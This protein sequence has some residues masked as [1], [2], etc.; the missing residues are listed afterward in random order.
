MGVIMYLKPLCISIIL[1]CALCAF[2]EPALSISVSLLSGGGGES[3]SSSTTYNLDKSAF[4]NEQISLDSGKL[5]QN[6]QAGGSGNNFL[7]QQV[8]DGTHSLVNAIKSEGQFAS[9]SS[10]FASS[11]SSAFD[12]QVAGKGNLDTVIWGNDGSSSAGQQ[13]S[14]SMGV[15]ETRQSLLADGSVSTGQETGMAGIKGRIA[16]GVFSG[17]DVVGY[18][19]DFL[20][21]SQMKAAIAARTGETTTNFQGSISIDGATY[22]DETT[23]QALSD[24]TGGMSVEGL[25]ASEY[26][27]SSFNV[28]AFNMDESAFMSVNKAGI[29]SET[30]AANAG[31][32][33]SYS[34]WTEDGYPMRWNTKEPIQLY[35]NDASLAGTGITPDDAKLA[36]DFA[37]NSWDSAVAKNLFADGETVMSSSL[38][39]YNNNDGFSVHGWGSLDDLENGKL[40]LSLVNNRWEDPKVDGFWSIKESDV[41]YNNRISWYDFD[42]PTVALHN[43][44]GT[45][46]LG[47]VDDPSQVMYPDYE[48]VKRDLSI[49]D[50]YGA[51]SL[52]GAG[53]GLIGDFDGDGRS[54]IIEING[55]DYLLTSFSGGDGQFYPVYFSPWLGYGTG[56]GAWGVSDV[57]GDGKDDLQH[58]WGG[59]YINTWISN[60]DG[61]YYLRSFQPWPGYGTSLGSWAT[62]DVNGDG[63]GDLQHIWGGDYIN[64]WI[65][66]GDGTYQ[67]KSFQPWPG[68]GTSLGEWGTGDVNG[69]GKD[70]LQHIWGGDYIN[71]WISEGD[72]TYQMNS[73]QPWPGYGTSLGGWFLGDVD[74]DG[75]SDLEH[76]WGGDYINTWISKGDGTYQMKS[77]QPWPG[78]GTSLGLWTLGDIT[79]D[80]KDDLQHIWGGDY[81]NSW[82]SKGDGTYQVVPFQPWPGYDSAFG[83]YH[84]A[85]YDGDGKDDLLHLFGGD[86]PYYYLWTSNGDGTFYSGWTVSGIDP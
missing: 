69:D 6:R 45:I 73:F 46:G 58:V 81:F 21:A 35:L 68:Y 63:K 57:N 86:Y 84:T 50:I 34:L 74:G 72:G 3:V 33:E 8:N 24:G 15:I 32:H 26:G 47:A 10:F 37:A 13:A 22:L 82:I 29:V 17:K 52:Y 76:I 42:L 27:L 9:A 80:G 2:V 11:D 75:K 36:I 23:V 19:G 43:I 64:T 25:H 83:E 48:G 49:G 65:S 16:E 41:I 66:K 70:D 18:G 31:T 55:E 77:F 12:Q 56:L 30:L 1:L 61:S 14:V 60:G 51:Q 38:N 78:Y 59:D 39:P 28:K 62:A 54:D 4:L 67:M 71:T 40:S 7:Q 44:G 5:Y 79:G 85:D 20:G 53:M